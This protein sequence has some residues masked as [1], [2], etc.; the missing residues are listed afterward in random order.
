[1]QSEMGRDAQKAQGNVWREARLRA[2]EHDETLYSRERVSELLGVGIDAVRR[3]ETNANKSMPV[4]TAVLMADL[5]NAPELLNYYCLNECPI[6]CNRPL[7]TDVVGIERVTVK[8]LKSLKAEELEE[9]KD[10]LLDIP[11]TRSLWT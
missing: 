10:K 11:T 4:D 3:I 7:S 9:M 1:M 5:Y 2:A 6:G 8:L